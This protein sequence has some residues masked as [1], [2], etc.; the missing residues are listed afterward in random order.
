VSTPA[1]TCGANSIPIVAKQN[2]VCVK[3]NQ[4]VVEEA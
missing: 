2:Y 4:V 3:V 1:P